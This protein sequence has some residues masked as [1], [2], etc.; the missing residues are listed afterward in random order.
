MLAGVAGHHAGLAGGH[1]AQR[2]APLPRHADRLRPLLGEIAAV[3]D[4]HAGLRVAERVR[5]H[6]L[7]PRQHPRGVPR[8]LPDELLQHLHVPVGQRQRQRLDGLALQVKQLPLQVAQGPPALLRARE[9][10]REQG[11][12]RGEFVG[13]RRHIARGQVDLRG[14]PRGRRDQL[15]GRRD[16]VHL[17][18]SRRVIQQDRGHLTL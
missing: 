17:V 4:Q 10:R 15:Q 16:R 11:V 1:L 6:L 8:A 5:H 14:P 12:V 13:Q 7:V 3:H 2:P 18:S 9:G